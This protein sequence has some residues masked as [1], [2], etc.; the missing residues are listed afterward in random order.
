MITIQ[1][2]TPA[3][4]ILADLIW[5]APSQEEVDELIRKF[6]HDARVVRDMILFEVIDDELLE[7]TEFKMAKEVINSVK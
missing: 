2:F 7:E 5:N 3:Q 6:G 1:G 4:R